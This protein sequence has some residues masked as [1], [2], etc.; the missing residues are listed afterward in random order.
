MTTVHRTEGDRGLAAAVAQEPTDAA[1]VAARRW[2]SRRPLPW[3][4]AIAGVL[5]VPLALAFGIIWAG[6]GL[7]G[8]APGA[9][10][11]RVVSAADMEQEYGIKVDLVAVIAAGGLVDLRFTVV[12]KDKA[13]HF[14][15]DAASLPALYVESTGAVLKTSRAKAHKMTVLDG[16]SYFVLYPNSGGA[17]QAGTGVSVVIEGI[18]LEPIVAQS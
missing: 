4:T 6:P 7:A 13:Q 11:A 3:L 1:P 9:A 14:L 5:V 8:G 17:V 15:H 10:D 16:A 18:R 2:P 12:D